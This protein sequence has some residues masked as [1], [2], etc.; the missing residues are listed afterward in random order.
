MFAATA[1]F[2]RDHFWLSLGVIFYSSLL[3]IA[4]LIKG[5]HEEKLGRNMELIN[6][7]FLLLIQYH[8]FT[9][10]DFVKPAD[11]RVVMGYSIIAFTCLSIFVN[12][13][14][15]GVVIGKTLKL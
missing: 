3:T 10:T 15:N 12:I 6:E 7:L 5:A 1:F 4:L 2:A 9:F 13:V 14:I 8:L 11:T